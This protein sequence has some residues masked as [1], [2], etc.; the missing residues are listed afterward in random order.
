MFTIGIF[1][2]ELGHGLFFYCSQFLFALLLIGGAQ[3]LV[4]PLEKKWLQL[5][6]KFRQRL[7]QGDLYL[8]TA[9]SGDHFLLQ[10]NDLLNG[11]VSCGQAG[12]Q[13]LAA[14]LTGPGF[15]HVNRILRAGN[16]KVELAPQ[17]LLQVRVNHRLPVHQARHNRS[18]RPAERNMGN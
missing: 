11:F 18:D 15:D 13:I 17:G 12:Q 16:D 5:C 2:Q 6:R 1:L 10:R 3:S 7:E 9:H 8:G 14:D 4:D